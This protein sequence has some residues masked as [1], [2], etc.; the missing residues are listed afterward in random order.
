MNSEG[1]GKACHYCGKACNCLAADPGMWPVALAH[2]DEPGVVK[3]HHGGC[4]SERLALLDASKG[5][6]PKEA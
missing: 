2:P 4:I 3:W 5:E 1:H 6:K